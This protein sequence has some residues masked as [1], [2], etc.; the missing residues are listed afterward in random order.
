M[1]EDSPFHLNVEKSGAGGEYVVDPNDIAKITMKQTTECS[2][3]HLNVQNQEPGGAYQVSE[4]QPTYVQRDTTNYGDYSAGGNSSGLHLVDNYL[5]Q[6]NNNNKQQ[7]E[8]RIHGNMGMFNGEI[9]QKYHNGKVC[10]QEYFSG[11]SFKQQATPTVEQH[12][13]LHGTQEYII[14]RLV[15][16]D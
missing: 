10:S 1:T 3:F 6:R 15:Q 16:T 12:G 13:K 8:A 4:Q 5:R 14:K 9:N 11:P 2:P 7:A